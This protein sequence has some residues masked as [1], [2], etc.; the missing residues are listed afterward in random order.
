M[1]KYI[2]YIIPI[3]AVIIVSCNDN[4]DNADAP[5]SPSLFIDLVDE[6]TL[7]NVF[8]DSTYLKE[9][10]TIK[11]VEDNDVPFKVIVDSNILHVV[12]TNAVVENDTVFV[13]LNNPET[14]NEDEFEVVYST[15][16]KKEECYTLYK[17]NQVQFLYRENEEANGIHKVKI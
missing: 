4:C 7:E 13:R 16:A 11:D 6:T 2:S 12:L 3:L 15:E 1:K 9:Q 10:L 5:S 17:V 14:L 8:T